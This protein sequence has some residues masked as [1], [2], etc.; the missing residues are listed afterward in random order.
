VGTRPAAGLGLIAILLGAGLLAST[1]VLSLWRDAPAG[2]RVTD[3]FRSTLSTPGLDNLSA[4]FNALDAFGTQF[5]DGTRPALA[6]ELGMSQAQFDRFVAARY[7]NTAAAVHEVPPALAFVRPV[8]PQLKSVHDDFQAVD[9]IPG[10]GLPI[11]AVPWLLV[12]LAGLLGVGGVLVWRRPG[13][14][15]LVLLLGL[16]VGMIAVPLALDL[17]HKAAAAQR[18]V[19]VGEVSLS[20]NAARTATRTVQVV[21]GTVREVRTELI[22]TLAKRLGT[23][24]AAVSA[25]LARDFPKVG[26]GLAEWD[27]IKVGAEQLTAR[28]RASV[29]DA[30]RM[31]DVPFRA[32]PWLVLGPG[33][34]VTL[35]AAGALAATTRR[36]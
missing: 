13:R 18:V 27:R 10:L 23:T 28:Q 30:Q 24:P 6:R 35:L 25:S 5:I 32:L 29:H 9:D 12:G 26:T 19:K 33:I 7:P 34:L 2:E 4:N 16:G 14:V 21:D 31:K 15:P 36:R 20:A 22:P 8:I 1:F 3:R 11:T 17:P